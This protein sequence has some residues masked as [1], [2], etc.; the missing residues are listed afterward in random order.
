M[1]YEQLEPIDPREAFTMTPCLDTESSYSAAASQAAMLLALRNGVL[2]AKPETEWD[3]A[4]GKGEKF[5]LPDM[6]PLRRVH[7]MKVSEATD[8]LGISA[9][10]LQQEK[11]PQLQ[12]EMAR[13][14]HNVYEKPSIEATASL[15]EAAMYSQHPLVAVAA[16]AGARE[17]TRLRKLIHTTLEQGSRSEDLLTA[18]LAKAALSKIIPKDPLVRKYVIP[19]PKSR[20]RRR[21]SNTSVITHGTFASNKSWYQPGGQF[22]T[23]LEA[24]RPDLH[25]HDQS[26]KW[27][28]AYSPSARKADAVLLNQWIGDQGL[29]TPDFFAHS[30]GGT[31]A[32]LATRQGAQFNRLV[33]MSWPVHERWFPNFA[34]VNKIV[35]IRVRLDL[36]I[37]IDGGD[38]RFRTN[39]FNIEEHRHGWFNHSAT[40][41]PDYWDDHDLWA[42]ITA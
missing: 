17:T 7:R 30:H 35:D 40:H 9:K 41:D 32:H 42:K 34:H 33:L 18:R 20:K 13:I 31:V 15:F 29:T 3:A 28:G 5:T 24:N 14:V 37:M 19:Q 8:Y 10:E 23:A 12:D 39:Q 26:F 27:T 38:Q 2:G 4:E 21:K 1:G 36:V 11:E 22:Y 6:K 16:A 25:V